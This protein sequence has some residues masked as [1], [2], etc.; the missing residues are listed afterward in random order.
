MS[1]PSSSGSS[2]Y[3]AAKVDGNQMYNATK[4]SVE[5]ITTRYEENSGKSGVTAKIKEQMHQA[6]DTLENKMDTMKEKFGDAVSSLTGNE[7]NGKQQALNARAV[8]EASRSEEQ[9]KSQNEDRKSQLTDEAF[10]NPKEKTP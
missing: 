3:K 6:A 1:G 9:K 2:V 4:R 10:G 5:D 8:W 7:E